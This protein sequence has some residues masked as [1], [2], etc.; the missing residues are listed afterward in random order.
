MEMARKHGGGA[1]REGERR[2][3]EEVG[4]SGGHV[5]FYQTLPPS[6]RCGAHTYAGAPH[7]CSSAMALD[8]KTMPERNKKR[9]KEG[10]G[11]GKEWQ[12]R[13]YF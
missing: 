10:K 5:G 7:V 9:G 2:R 1:A 6:K 12:A 13:E 8:L 3:R 11:G 4:V